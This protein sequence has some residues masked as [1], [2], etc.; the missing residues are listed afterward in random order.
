M[1]ER[2][3]V[4]FPSERFQKVDLGSIVAN[5]PTTWG[6]LTPKIKYSVDKPQ[7][8]ATCVLQVHDDNAMQLNS[9]KT[10]I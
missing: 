6:V 9:S 3:N 1:R 8:F 4:L 5:S 7:F 10:F 2:H